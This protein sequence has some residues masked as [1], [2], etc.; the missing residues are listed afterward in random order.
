MINSSLLTFFCGLW[1]QSLRNSFSFF[2]EHREYNNSVNWEYGEQSIVS[3]AS[4]VRKHYGLEAF[5]PSNPTLDKWMN[6]N[7]F[8]CV[9]LFLVDAMGTSIL[10]KHLPENA[11][12]LQNLN[13]ELVSVFPTATTAATT[14]VRNGRT[15]GETGWFGWCQYF[16][17]Q[18]DLIIPFLGKGMYSEKNYGRNFY[19]T[20]L[21]LRLTVDELNEA[22]IPAT[23]VWPS[24]GA[25]NPCDDISSVMDK[26]IE[27]AGTKRFRHIYAYWDLLDTIMHRNGTCSVQA[28]E[29]TLRINQL[30]EQFASALPKGTGVI[31]TA[32]HGQLDVRNIDLRTYPDLLACLNHL[33]SM[34]AR[35]MAFSV[36]PEAKERFCSLFESCLGKDFLLL[37]SE[38][39]IDA[40]LFGK[41]KD[42]SHYLGDFIA[43]SKSD[44][45]LALTD[46]S[47]SVAGDHGSFLDDE[48][49]IP[50]ILVDNALQ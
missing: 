2:A 16:E 12:L 47:M 30:F 28:R 1:K 13:Q 20:V 5:S 14:A 45:R 44:A 42:H 50:M 17:E 6:E 29:E 23:S 22:G 9:V 8:D 40:G 43:C 39:Q 19:E 33:P 10:K 3:I 21:P 32:D 36:K 7:R 27:L 26:V 11:F 41:G 24:W 35:F 31:I 37:S 34:E 48:K 49:M 25:P 15:P 4:S 18:N 38:E 46:S